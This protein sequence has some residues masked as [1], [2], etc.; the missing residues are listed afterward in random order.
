MIEAQSNNL[1]SQIEELRYLM[2][3]T[4][5]TYGLGSTDT[6]RYSEELDKLIMQAQLQGKC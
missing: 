4:A 6:L 1:Y 3:N 2:I 5:K